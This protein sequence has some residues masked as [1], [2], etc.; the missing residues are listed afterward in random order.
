MPTRYA[1]SRAWPD[2]SLRAEH[3]DNSLMMHAATSHVLLHCSQ[4]Q[5]RSQGRVPVS[6]ARRESLRLPTQV[7]TASAGRSHRLVQ[8][9]AGVGKQ[10]QATAVRD[11]CTRS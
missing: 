6:G 1:T 8:C 5:G 10:A 4:A 11:G 9:S 7:P 2:S 3:S